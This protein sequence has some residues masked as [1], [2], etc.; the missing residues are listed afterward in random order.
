MSSEPGFRQAKW[1]RKEGIIE[2]TVFE[3]SAGRKEGYYEFSMDEEILSKVGNPIDLVP[4][5]LRRKKLNLPNLSEPE[6]VRHFS[7][8]AQMNYGIDSGPYWLGSCTMKY[9]PKVNEEIAKS[10]KVRRLHPYQPIETVQ[11]ALQI[12][13]E[14]G[15]TLAKI[16]G[17]RHWTFQTAAGAHGE[18]LGCAIIRAYHVDRGEARRDEMLIP[19]SAHGSNFASAAM[20]GFKVIKIPLDERGCT[21]ISA[22][23]A[24]AG[25]RTA[26][27]MITNP[28]TLGIFEE[29]ILEISDIV[30]ASG[31]LLYYDGANMNA[32]L[33]RVL[34]SDM[35]VD[36]A[37][38]N[39]H[40]TFSTPHGTGGPGA[41]A[42]L[43]R[44]GLE[45]FLPVPVLRKKGDFY[46]FDYQ[47]PKSVGRVRA[48]YG[49]FEVLVRAW[50]YLKS[51]GSRGLLEVSGIA[52]LNS[53][54]AFNKIKELKYVSVEHGGDK[55][56]K[57]EFVVSLKE[58][59][60]K[61]TS[62][63]LLVAKRL[64]DYG[65][66]PP[67]IYFP[68]VVEEAF[69]IEPTESESKEDIDYYVEVMR[70]VLEEV[71]RRPEL[72]LDAPRN[73]SIDRLDEVRAARQ[74]ILSWKIY[75]R[76]YKTN[77]SLD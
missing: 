2:P 29:D 64:L 56:R 36:L 53:N 13:Y 50:A 32:L 38:L 42:F 48:F 75:E 19:L 10:K 23:R 28:N 62:P 59:R 44:D 63:A 52:V 22:L 65:V 35:G 76:Y 17:L 21:D 72:F 1:Q 37:H 71:D 57:H 5:K 27:M 77:K 9:N 8:L 68:P 49:N 14:L 40:K 55:P 54:Y 66:H 4:E 15:E 34:L 69:M 74:P 39:L 3:L 12:M 41:G 30:H 47:V 45:D 58:A 26:G 18:Y 16:T 43:V 61:I 24:A 67:T 20:A 73:S 31:G 46:Y 6:V 11:G 60:S 33:G 51:L 25:E 70:R 7:R